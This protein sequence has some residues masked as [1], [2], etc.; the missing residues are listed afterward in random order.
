MGLSSGFNTAVCYYTLYRGSGQ[1]KPNS[2]LVQRGDVVL[3]PARCRAGAP[4]GGGQ[5]C[6]NSKRG[7]EATSM[8]REV[9]T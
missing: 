6:Q 9:F 5:C 2:V 4:L 7:F 1:D 8:P 3:C